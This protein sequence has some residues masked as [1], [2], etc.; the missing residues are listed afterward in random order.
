[1]KYLEEEVAEAEQEKKE[2]EKEQ[3]NPNKSKPG[4]NMLQQWNE[5]HAKRTPIV[6]FI[7]HA[8]RQT[9]EYKAT[10]DSVETLI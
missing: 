8:T 2:I 1:M 6:R 4:Q 5:Y 10:V 7:E 3:P 9:N